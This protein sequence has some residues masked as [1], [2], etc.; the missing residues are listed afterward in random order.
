[1]PLAYTVLT[2]LTLRMVTL[3][4]HRGISR[5]RP[6]MVRILVPSPLRHRLRKREIQILQSRLERLNRIP[7]RSHGVHSPHA[8]SVHGAHNSHPAHGHPGPA[9]R[10]LEDLR[11]RLRKREIQILQSRLER[12]N[13]IP[14]RRMGICFTGG[15]TALT[16]RMVCTAPMPL[17]YTVLTIL[18]LRMVTLGRC[19]L[20][21]GRSGDDGLSA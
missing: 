10:D 1:M 6:L 2:I 3:G 4:R 13:R 14:V 9:P 16:A 18:T 8:A 21:G 12:L 5:M 11:H 17:A 7:V 19:L 15:H 20:N